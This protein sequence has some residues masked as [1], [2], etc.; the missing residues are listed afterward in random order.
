M[1]G[2]VVSAQNVQASSWVHSASSP[3]SLCAIVFPRQQS[4]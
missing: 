3:F 4:S 1:V 2:E